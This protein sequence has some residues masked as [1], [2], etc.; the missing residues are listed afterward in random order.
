MAEWHSRWFELTVTD[1]DPYGANMNRAERRS[2]WRG[3]ESIIDPG[4][5]GFESVESCG[6]D[7]VRLVGDFVAVSRDGRRAFLTVSRRHNAGAN[8]TQQKAS[9]AIPSRSGARVTGGFATVR[10]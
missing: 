8:V 10:R 6:N 1:R 5:G 7:A 4:D 9:A 3:F 2:F